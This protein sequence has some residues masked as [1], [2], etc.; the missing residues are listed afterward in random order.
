MAES[1]L[2]SEP[3]QKI[4]SLV[5]EARERIRTVSE[6]P[7]RARRRGSSL[8]RNNVFD[9]SRALRRAILPQSRPL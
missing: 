1:D 8:R 4:S 7:C 5:S 3:G 6:F 9:A 2:G